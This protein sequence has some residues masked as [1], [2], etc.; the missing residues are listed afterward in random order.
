MRTFITALT[1][2]LFLSSPLAASAQSYAQPDNAPDDQQVRGRI[3]NFDGDYNLQVRDEQ[4]NLDNV[5][6]HQGTIIN[7]TGLTLEPGMIVS[8]LGYNAGSFFAANEVDT[9]YTFVADQPYY[10]GHPWNY[11]G[12]SVGLDFFFGS[13]G[14]WHGDGFGGA[15]FTYAN[16]A[17]AYAN[18]HVRSMYRGGTFQGRNYVAPREEGGYY[19]G[20]GGAA[21][22]GDRGHH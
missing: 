11:Y 3:V 22:G 1:A 12:P 16:G 9:P 10:D 5:E 2:A 13:N 18:A 4:G 7:P 14:W 8:I 19:G 20:H 21:H 6:L 15:N 17:R